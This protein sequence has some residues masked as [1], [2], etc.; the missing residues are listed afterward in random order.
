MLNL[1]SGLDPRSKRLSPI[2]TRQF[3][4]PEMCAEN[5]FAKIRVADAALRDLY[6]HRIQGGV[7]PTRST[8]L[9]RSFQ[10][11]CMRYGQQ[12]LY[13]TGKILESFYPNN[14]VFKFPSH[15][16]RIEVESTTKNYEGQEDM[17]S[18]CPGEDVIIPMLFNDLLEQGL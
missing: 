8:L 3:S 18:E 10:K 2:P 7:N 17:S 13:C 16:P 1:T 4:V 6:R 12:K 5:A 15:C 14:F 11:V 9:I